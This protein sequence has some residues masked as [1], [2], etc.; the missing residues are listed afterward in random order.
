VFISKGTFLVTIVEINTYALIIFIFIRVGELSQAISW[1]KRMQLSGCLTD[2]VLHHLFE[3]ITDEEVITWLRLIKSKGK[4]AQSESSTISEQPQLTD[5]ELELPEDNVEL[6]WDESYV[7]RPP[8]EIPALNETIAQSLKKIR[9]QLKTIADEEE[10]QLS[11]ISIHLSAHVYNFVLKRL[12][13]KKNIYD[14]L[15]ILNMMSSEKKYVGDIT[16]TKKILAEMIFEEKSIPIA[17]SA[18]LFDSMKERM[19]LLKEKEEKEML[20]TVKKGKKKIKV[21]P[22]TEDWFSLLPFYEDIAA[23]KSTQ[24]QE[25]L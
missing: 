24:K 16:D 19:N 5:P 11:G 15:D 6:E 12:A 13:T 10:K 8:P 7:S 1:M 9:E 3:E 21:S 20:S 4:S 25:D 22:W 14:A 18:H 2:G 17:Y 23:K